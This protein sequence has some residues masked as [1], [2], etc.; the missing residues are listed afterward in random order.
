MTDP[1]WRI[2]DLVDLEFFLQCDEK[3]RDD[4]TALAARDR[5]LYLSKIQPQLPEPDSPE[6]DRRRILRQWL[7]ERR[8][9]EREARGEDIPL[10]GETASEVFRLFAVTGLILGVL[11]GGGVAFSLLTYTGLQ[12]LNVSVYLGILVLPQ[13]LLLF[14]MLLMGLSRKVRRLPF[15]S[16]SALI[17]VMG[18]F[19]ARLTASARQKALRRL[20]GEQRETLDAVMGLIQ[21][22]RRVYGGLFHWP[23]FRILQLFGIGFNLGAIGATLLRIIGSDVAF[24]WQSTVQFS[25]EAAYQ[26]V[27]IIALPWSWLLPAGLAHPTLAEIEGSRI[28]LKEGIYH[29]ATLDLVSWWPF[30]LLTLAVYGLL[31]RLLLWVVGWIAERRGLSRL[32][33]DHADA[34]RVVRRMRTPRFVTEGRP[35]AERPAEAPVETPEPHFALACVADDEKAR[36]ALV[37]DDIFD[38]CPEG[39]LQS[40]VAGQLGY[41]VSDRVRVNLDPES[42]RE[43]IRAISARLARRNGT[44]GILI[45][46]EA[47]QPPIREHFGFLKALREAVGERVR[48]DIGLIGRPDPATIFTPAAAGDRDIWLNKIRVLGDPYLRVERLVPDGSEPRP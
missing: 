5:E 24:G 35:S 13:V 3:N 42:D 19:L 7:T 10:P 29:L 33:L 9:L 21:G 43:R 26:A 4:E 28:I 23:P 38:E 22:R 6:P 25:P 1:P 8:R 30:L 11:T 15:P 46:Q 45:V 18:G 17:S 44:A 20:S 47:W 36:V 14:L 39:E 2:P 16:G 37:P 31:P 34:E 27:R 12:P 40:V 48:I 32:A 41:P